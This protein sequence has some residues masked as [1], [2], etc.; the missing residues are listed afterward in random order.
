MDCLSESPSI[1]REI[2]QQ[3]DIKD[4][5]EHFVACRIIISF[6]CR[7]EHTKDTNEPYFEYVFENGRDNV[8]IIKWDDPYLHTFL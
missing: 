7:L 8:P 1:V 6:P 5:C 3:I 4:F 2:D